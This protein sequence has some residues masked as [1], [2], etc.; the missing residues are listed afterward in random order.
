M[1]DTES[2]QALLR[3]VMASAAAKAGTGA[4]AGPGAA[5]SQDLLYDEDGLP[6]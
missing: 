1:P 3:A 4:S 2:R 6:A 5:R